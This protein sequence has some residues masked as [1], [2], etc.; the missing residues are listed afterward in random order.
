MD[1]AMGVEPTSSVWQTEILTVKLRLDGADGETQ[2]H[3]HSITSRERYR[4]RH[5]GRKER[6]R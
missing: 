1:E 6:V 3:S 5:I 2:T 4:L